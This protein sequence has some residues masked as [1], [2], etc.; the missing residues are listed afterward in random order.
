MTAANLELRWPIKESLIAYIENLDDGVVEVIEPAFRS[1][2]GFHFPSAGD[3]ADGDSQRFLGTVRLKGHWGA[4]DIELRDPRIDVETDSGAL[5]VRERGGRDGGRMLRFADLVFSDE[6]TDV[7]GWDGRE[8]TASL[9]GHGQILLGGQYR[10]GEVLS[11]LR[12]VRH[13]DDE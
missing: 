4:L 2:Q 13:H 8:A 1:D 10:I 11:P 3:N 7:D 6:K 5:L 12:V 9:T